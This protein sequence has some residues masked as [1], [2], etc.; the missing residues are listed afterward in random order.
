MTLFISHKAK[1]QQSA[2]LELM[3]VVGVPVRLSLCVWSLQE[4]PCRSEMILVDPQVPLHQPAHS[5]L[6]HWELLTK[7]ER[8]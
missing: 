1:C 3:L 6:C 4:Q 8:K 5:P 7:S 2:V